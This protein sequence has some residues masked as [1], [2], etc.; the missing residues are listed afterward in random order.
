M[1]Q[2][3]YSVLVV[4]DEALIRLRSAVAFETLGYK[5]FEA[6]HADAAISILEAHEEILMVVTD[7]HMPGT[8]DGIKLAH[9][10][11]NRWPPIHLIVVSGVPGGH[12]ELPPGA[13]FLNKPYDEDRLLSTAEALLKAAA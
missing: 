9:Y 4:E 10:V 11:R 12:T 7:V 2:L 1:D 6:P 3:P 13:I 8:M 5:V